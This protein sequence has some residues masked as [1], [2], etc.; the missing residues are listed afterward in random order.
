MKGWLLSLRARVATLSH[1]AA[2][3][4]RFLIWSDLN[5]IG[6]VVFIEKIHE[7]NIRNNVLSFHFLRELELKSVILSILWEQK[8]MTNLFLFY[9]TTFDDSSTACTSK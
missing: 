9:N 4:N 7:Y 2:D 5:K 8:K 6:D 3:T 1:M